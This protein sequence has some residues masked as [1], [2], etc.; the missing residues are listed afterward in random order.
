MLLIYLAS[1]VGL[2]LIFTAVKVSLFFCS[3]LVRFCF[4]LVFVFIYMLAEML[5]ILLEH[6]YRRYSQIYFCTNI[7]FVQLYQNDLNSNLLK[8]SLFCF[9]LF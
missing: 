8:F 9:I 7:F 4:L 6:D 5:Y 1:L 2:R 3:S